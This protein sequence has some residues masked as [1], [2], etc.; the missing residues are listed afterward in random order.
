MTT[1]GERFAQTLDA[2]YADHA[3][4]LR[5]R[6]WSQPAATDRDQGRRG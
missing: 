1:R 5:S 2:E 4:E 6:G 3:Q